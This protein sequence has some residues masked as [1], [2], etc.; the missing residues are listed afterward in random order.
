MRGIGK[1]WLLAFVVVIII[2]LGLMMATFGFGTVM[3]CSAIESIPTGTNECW[4][5]VPGK[6]SVE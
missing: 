2:V 1:G 5:P 6:I 4:N 3:K